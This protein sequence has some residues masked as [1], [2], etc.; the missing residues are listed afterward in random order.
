[1]EHNYNLIELSAVYEPIV[2]SLRLKVKPEQ[3]MIST[4]PSA[5]MQKY[6]N[7][8]KKSAICTSHHHLLGCSTRKKSISSTYINI[9]E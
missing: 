5:L 9:T 3:D 7:M 2:I 8:M 1:M 6:L 4:L